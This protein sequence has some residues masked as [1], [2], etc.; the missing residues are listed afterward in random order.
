MTAARRLNQK[1][2]VALSGDLI[3]ALGEAG[4][5]TSAEIVNALI[6]EIRD[7]RMRRATEH[8]KLRLLSGAWRTGWQD[9]DGG[10]L[11]EQVHGIL[12]DPPPDAPDR[13]A[14]REWAHVETICPNGCGWIEFCEC[15]KDGPM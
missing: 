9:F 13:A 14:V 3:Q 15:P 11:R 10:L 5:H 4:H 12:G 2:L 1:E 6:M 8:A 7:E